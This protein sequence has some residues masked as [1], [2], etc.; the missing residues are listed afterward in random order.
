MEFRVL[1]EHFERLEKAS[2]RLELTAG[3]IALLKATPRSLVDKVLYMTQGR[4][5]PDFVGVELGVAEKLAVRALSKTLGVAEEEVVAL[6]KKLGDIG[7]AAEEV[8][9]KRRQKTFGGES[10]TVEH[11]YETFEKIAKSTGTGSQEAK[12]RFLGEL[13]HNA[14][15]LEGRYLVRLVSGKLRL[16]VADQTLLEA[17]A[18]YEANREATSVVDLEAKDR[19]EREE[20]KRAVEK[21]MEVTSD[22]ALVAKTLIDGGLAAVKRLKV[23]L[24]V[25]IRPMLA[26]R[27]ET[28]EEAMERMGG[29]AQVEYKY[30]GLR[31]Q[32]HV[33]DKVD[34]FSRRLERI[35]G[36]FPDVVEA[37][38]SAR[39]GKKSFIV[40]GEAVAV[41]PKTGRIRPFQELATRRGRKY[42]LTG[43]GQ[44]KLTDIDYT[45]KVP[46]RLF[47]FDALY[48]DGQEI[49]D[50]PLRHRRKRL[51]GLF[52]ENDHVVMAE[53]QEFDAVKDV[54][55]Y[56]DKV[57][58]MGAEGIMLK[59]PASAYQAG[60]RG[61]A[62]IKFKADY[63]EGAVDSFDLA[64]VGAY[65]GQGRR[66]GWYGGLLL[67]AVNE[68]TGEYEAVTRLATGFDDATLMGLEER[69][70]PFVSKSKPKRVVSEEE[71]DVWIEPKVVVEVVG[72]ELTLSP[73]YT[74][75]RGVFRPDA[76][77]SV[78]F[79]RFTGRWRDDKK[80]EQA[81]TDKELVKFYKMRLEASAGKP[82]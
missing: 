15:P 79:P 17:L 81:T 54:E 16:G 34:L 53:A 52:K 26:E 40:E 75:A 27:T 51:E 20:A 59:N 50:E 3:V 55:R 30:D 58:S 57:T 39:R 14:S 62:W 32:A 41:D 1:A 45:K 25:P 76:G 61:W 72:A 18:L 69:F 77:L 21:A 43:D 46:V 74:V 48:H 68:K 35:T 47:L 49:M 37:L 10:L 22:I 28:L 67:A 7:T 65:W 8:L 11:V 13:L 9:K 4:L 56:F 5:Y 63:Q 44:G 19:Q 38:E 70:R 78:R 36:Q 80:P 24:G 42:G 6:Q 33:G 66:S 31:I 71:P 23:K 29:V 12:L 73:R 60:N 2:K 82:A 64:V